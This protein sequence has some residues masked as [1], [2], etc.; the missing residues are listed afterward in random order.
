MTTGSAIRERLERDGGRESRGM[1][2][3]GLWRGVFDQ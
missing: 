2:G 1:K 3:G